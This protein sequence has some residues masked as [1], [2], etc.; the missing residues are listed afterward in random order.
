MTTIKEKKRCGRPPKAEYKE[1]KR[2]KRKM[3]TKRVFV[4]S[5]LKGNVERNMARAEIYCRFVFDEGYVPV[6]P[7]IYYPRFLD[8]TDKDERAAGIRYGLEEMWRCKQ[9]WVF[10]RVTDGMRAE[11]E[12]AKELKISVIYFDLDMEEI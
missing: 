10:G 11:I 1:P 5:P 6:A 12:L 8:D 9:V 3:P 2:P 7:H 4:C